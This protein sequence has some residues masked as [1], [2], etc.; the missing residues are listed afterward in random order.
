MA[1]L[2]AYLDDLRYFASPGDVRGGWRLL[3]DKGCLGCHSLSVRDPWAPRNLA[4][5]KGLDSPA[6]II[7]V[8]WNHVRVKVPGEKREVWLPCRP[9]EMADLM[10]WL[11]SLGVDA[12]T[13]GSER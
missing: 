6:A 5:V 2:V 8:L 1:H 3:R 11:G 9:G 10:A 4:L 13:P 12:V 7:S